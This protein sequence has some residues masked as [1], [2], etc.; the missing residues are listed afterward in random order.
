MAARRGCPKVASAMEANV[1]GPEPAR[2]LLFGLRRQAG[3]AKCAAPAWRPY[4]A[5]PYRSEP[6][7]GRLASRPH[8]Q[9]GEGDG[10]LV[11]LDGLVVAGRDATPLLEVVEAPSPA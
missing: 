9:R 3:A 7:P 6:R 8:Q 4:R 11:G 10:R 2:P 5:R 1:C